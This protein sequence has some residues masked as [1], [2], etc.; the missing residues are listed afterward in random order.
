MNG[1]KVLFISGSLGLGHIGRDLEIV[2]A[3]REKE[4]NIDV[5]WLAEDPASMV[6]EQAGEKLLPEAKSMA[7]GNA[8][9]D[10]SARDYNANLTRWV[11]NMRKGW[12]A[13]A[14]VVA[15]AVERERFDL[16]VGDEAYDVIIGM[17]SNVAMRFPFIMIYDFLGVDMVTRNPIDAV[18]TYMTNR[19]WANA[20][21]VE[22]PLAIRS[23]FIGEAEDVPNRKF[24]FMLPNRR[25]L[26]RKRVEF[27]GYI[28]SFNPEE[29]RNKERG[30]E[31]LGYGE[32][33]LIVCS[34][35]GT[36][37]GKDLLNLCAEAYPLIIEKLP[38]LRMILVCG[39]L[40]SPDSIKAPEGVEVRGYVPELFKHLAAAD[41]CIV[42]GGGTITLELTALQRPFLYFPLQQHFE[43]QVEVAPRCERHR[44][45][46]KMDYA[47]TTPEILANV[48][49]A[50]MD[51]NVDY[52]SIPVD[53]A[54]KAALIITQ[55]LTE[56]KP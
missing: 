25:E 2:K 49:L 6:L 34:I 16:V 21:K 36:S 52:A 46:I 51:Q 37:A 3:L 18:V 9:L 41:L 30:R 4:P 5:W 44:A 27:V 28:L 19:L 24:G 42:T 55:L 48:V 10:G 31:L 14:H 29:Y 56:K 35:G 54:Q 43:Q 38:S 7:P 13:N 11:K 23:L 39:P 26:A 33:P 20:L 50:N 45:G 40:L 1:K 47:R 12:S 53:G 17:A 8:K 22:P 32:Q 15:K